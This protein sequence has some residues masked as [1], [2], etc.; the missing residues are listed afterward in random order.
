MTHQNDCIYGY[1]KLHRIHN[2]TTATPVD[3]RLAA[4]N[5]KAGKGTRTLDP[6]ITS[7]VLYQL[8][9]SSNLQCAFHTSFI[10]Y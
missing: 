2:K 8:S 10:I 9:Y 1:T 7:E 4:V 6:F 3:P 5:M